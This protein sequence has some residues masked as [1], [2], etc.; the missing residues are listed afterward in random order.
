MPRTA[1]I[2]AMSPSSCCTWPAPPMY[3]SLPRALMSWASTAIVPRF[4]PPTRTSSVVLFVKDAST[5]ERP[6]PGRRACHDGIVALARL[7]AP[8]RDPLSIRDDVARSVEP[9]DEPSSE[10]GGCPVRADH[11]RIG[12]AEIGVRQALSGV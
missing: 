10:A 7:V 8:H 11:D 12:R 9:R 5:K 2:S 4:R 1:T 3:T 6:A